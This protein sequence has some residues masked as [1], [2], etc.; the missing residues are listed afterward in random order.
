MLINSNKP[1]TVVR[2]GIGS[3]TY[4]SYEYYKTHKLNPNYLHPETRTLY[5]AGIYTRDGNLYKMSL[6]CG[7]YLRAIK[8]SDAIASFT[9]IIDNQENF[10]SKEFNIPQINNNK[11]IFSYFPTLN[12]F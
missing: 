11:I 8:Y 1:F 10:F 12:F 5:N 4:M 7:H 9:K 3:E 6:F 2:L